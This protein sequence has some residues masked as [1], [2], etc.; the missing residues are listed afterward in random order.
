MNKD[1]ILTVVDDNLGIINDGKV[2]FDG[3]ISEFNPTFDIKKILEQLWFT[4]EIKEW[5]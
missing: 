5:N 2:I 1:I 3:M 4:L